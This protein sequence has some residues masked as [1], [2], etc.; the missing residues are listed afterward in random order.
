MTGTGHHLE[1]KEI[2]KDEH[3]KEAGMKKWRLAK[4]E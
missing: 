1:F 2:R 3:T 4:L